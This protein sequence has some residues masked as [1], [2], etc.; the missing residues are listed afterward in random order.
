MQAIATQF[1]AP[2]WALSCLMCGGYRELEAGAAQPI[3]GK[4]FQCGAKPFV[5]QALNSR[6]ASMTAADNLGSS[7]SRMPTLGGVQDWR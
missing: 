6:G 1:D 7:L 5:V 3:A 4:C 2:T